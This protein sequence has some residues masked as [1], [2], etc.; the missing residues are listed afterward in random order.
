[1]ITKY[2]LA[3]LRR[4]YNAYWVSVDYMEPMGSPTWVLS[5]QS[6]GLGNKRKEIAR[7]TGSLTWMLYRE[8]VRNGNV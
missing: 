6:A 5:A 4:K 1:M 2:L 7:T 3:K 8:S